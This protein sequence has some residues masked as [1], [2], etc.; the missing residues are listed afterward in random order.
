VRVLVVEDE[1]RIRVFVEKGLAAEGY[2][3]DTAG[4]VDEALARARV[5]VPDLAVVDVML[6]GADDGF[7]LLR[8]LR[9]LAPNLPVIML[10]ARSDVEDRV[11]GLD[12]GAADY[13]TKPFAFDELVARVRAH[14]RRG[15]EVGGDEDLLAVGSVELALRER[16][17]SVDGVRHDL[18]PREFA[19]L[20]Y[21]MRHPGQVLSRQRLL[22]GVWGFHFDPGSNVVDVY[23]RYLR[24]KIGA[25]RIETVRGV[26]YRLRRDG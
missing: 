10:T 19:L 16:R 2:A 15:T 3:V 9:G 22:S 12:L 4:G 6:A 24:D 14:L 20:A 18:P 8:Q 7:E 1:V 17:V 25:S 23:V 5:A 13:M 26:G 11:R 21:L